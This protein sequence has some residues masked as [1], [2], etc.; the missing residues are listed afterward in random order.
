M[1]IKRLQTPTKP[2]GS[3]PDYPVIE[4]E[5]ATSGEITYQNAIVKLT[6]RVTNQVSKITTPNSWLR[7]TMES[8][9]REEKEWFLEDTNVKS[10]SYQPKDIT[11]HSRWPQKDYCFQL[12]TSIGK[13]IVDLMQE[14]LTL[15]EAEEN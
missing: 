8:I 5:I 13:V 6:L 11:I 10:Q 14:E 3:K 7:L 15:I 1:S 12:T 9:L 4:K 2:A